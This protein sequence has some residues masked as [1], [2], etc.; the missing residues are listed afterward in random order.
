MKDFEDFIEEFNFA[1]WADNFKGKGGEFGNFDINA[2]DWLEEMMEEF[3]DAA[4][5][6]AIFFLSTQ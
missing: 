3:R 6:K 2:C 4:W 5:Y 1:E